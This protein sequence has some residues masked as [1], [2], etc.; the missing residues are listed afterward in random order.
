M[1]VFGPLI[2]CQ[3]GDPADKFIAT[4]DTA[5]PEQ[6]VPN[7]DQTRRLMLRPAPAV[8][9][10]APDFTLA[11]ADG[12]KAITRSKF[13]PGKPQVLIFGSWT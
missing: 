2:G 12:T 4:M 10:D 11:S 8:G 9:Q 7:W 13:S 1:S 5:P 3:G 6:R